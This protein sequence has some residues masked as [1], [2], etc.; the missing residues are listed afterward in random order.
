MG[1]KYEQLYRLKQLSFVTGIRRHTLNKVPI[2]QSV[3]HAL[4]HF[5]CQ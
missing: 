3:S 2:E 1:T 5:A 4:T